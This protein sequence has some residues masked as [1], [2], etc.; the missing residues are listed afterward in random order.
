MREK[1]EKMSKVNGRDE[2]VAG[3][4]V[5]NKMKYVISKPY[6]PTRK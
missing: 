6:R 4:K 3:R 5:A 1:E 2:L